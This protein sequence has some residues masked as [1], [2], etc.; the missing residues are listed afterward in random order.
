MKRSTSGENC[1]GRVLVLVEN[2]SV[3][4]DQRVWREAMTLTEA[5]YKVSVICPK[6][7]EFDAKS[8]EVIKGVSIYRYGAHEASSGLFSYMIEYFQAVVMMFLLSIVVF[9][10]E[11]FDVIQMCNPPDL[12]FL[13]TLPY[14]LIGKK[15]IFDHHDLSPETYLS[16][17][18]EPKKNA[19]YKALRFLEALTLKTADV[20]MSTNESYKELAIERGNVAPANIFVV[21]NGPDPNRVIEVDKNPALRHG[22]KYLLFY[23]GTMGQQDGVDY[24]LR[25]IHHLHHE[26]GRDDFHALIMGGGIELEN[27]KRYSSELNVDDVVTFTGRIPDEE[28]M[29]GLS[30]AD[31]CVCPDPMGPLNDVSTMNK[32]LEYMTMSKP[33]AAFDLK[34]TKV[35]AGDAALY[36]APNDEKD[37]ADK[38]AQ[39]LDSP[40][41]RDKLGRSGKERIDNGLSWEFSKRPLCDAYAHA[42]GKQRFGELHGERDVFD[43]HRMRKLYYG[44]R[45]LLPRRFQLFLRRI[46]MKRI[47]R[48]CGDRWFI[49]K[50]TALPP[51]GWPG[52]PDGKKFA[53]VLTHDVEEQGGYEKCDQVLQIE[54]KLGF[55][56]ALFL[57]PERYKV[58]KDARE[59]F[60]SRGFEIG[61]HGLKH[62]GK[63]YNSHENFSK[64]AKEIN[65]Y[66]DQWSVV[67]FRSPSM[68]HVLDWIHELNIK[69]DASTFDTDPFEPQ[70]VGAGTIFP[71]WVPG[72]DGSEGYLELPYTLPQDFTT[73]VLFKNNG[74]GLWKKKLA[75]IAEKGGMALVITHPDYMNFEGKPEFDEYPAS[76]YEDFLKHIEEDYERQYWNALPRDV[77]SYLSKSFKQG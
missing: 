29:E 40:E 54:E 14:K 34:E 59:N 3:P 56:S 36:A 15:V 70:P 1:V 74:I 10:R 25:A 7:C 75:W 39:L 49:T 4:G 18:R 9:F 77:T 30:T 71:N 76:L 65:E 2:N 55:R 31:V 41:L 45:P 67:G 21:R 72:D 57:V 20:I 52:W 68:H 50:S 11:G 44:V 5:G 6:R 27:L 64:R 42:L 38:I 8:H 62:D 19:V 32:T 58:A 26:C 69:Y 35:S 13:V 60:V 12:L 16:K 22:K 24:M 37:F 66:I 61:M 33:V 23:I 63:L 73:F 48:V 53:L 17:Q 51:N 47:L 46:R 28:V 43:S